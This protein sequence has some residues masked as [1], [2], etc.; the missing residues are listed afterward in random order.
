VRH[1][2]CP[3]RRGTRPRPAS[4][5]APSRKI[6]TS[7][8]PTR[9][10]GAARR[11]RGGWHL[12]GACSGPWYRP[13][14]PLFLLSAPF[15]G[16]VS[17]FLT[18]SSAPAFSCARFQ[19]HSHTC[20]TLPF[21]GRRAPSLPPLVFV[22]FPPLPSFHPKTSTAMWVASRG[23]R[24]GPFV[25]SARPA[26]WPLRNL[27]CALVFHNKIHRGRTHVCVLPP[28]FNEA[29]PPVISFFE[30]ARMAPT[31]QQRRRGPSP[32]PG[33]LPAL[34]PFP[35][36]QCNASSIPPSSLSVQSQCVR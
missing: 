35:L 24:G 21:A 2:G 13:P 5:G 32:P 17:Q 12:T 23:M 28:G 33:H 29:L 14:S 6:R 15:C 7:P 31:P 36:L 20:A 3:R 26:C 10:G 22:L 18:P 30:V 16:W 8:P 1:A 11:A 19:A 25:L 9:C 34:A 4:L 27:I